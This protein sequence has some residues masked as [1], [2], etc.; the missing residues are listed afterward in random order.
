MTEKKNEQRKLYALVGLGVVLVL[1]ISV[2]LIGRK[3]T[4]PIPQKS[5]PVII[6]Q[7]NNI[8][9]TG[10]LRNQH[11]AESYD[12][13]N[14]EPVPAVIRD[15]FMP[16]KSSSG[17]ENQHKKQNFSKPGQSLKLDGIVAGGKSPIAIINGTLV[18]LGDWVDEYQVVRIEKKEVF[19]DSGKER[20]TLKMVKE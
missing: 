8:P 13:L 12:P 15:I 20:L 1:V 19:L 5:S 16:L 18:F 7:F 14:R 9:E 3:T 10:K 17:T 6:P 4:P 11:D 2:R